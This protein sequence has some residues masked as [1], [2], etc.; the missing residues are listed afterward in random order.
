MRWRLIKHNHGIDIDIDNIPL[1]DEKTFELYQ[2]GET[3]RHFQFE[4]AGMQKYLR[5][6]KPDKFDD[7]I[8]MNALYRP[9]PM[10][11]IPNFI[12]RKHGREEISYDL[13][14]M[15][16]YLK[17]TY[18]ITVYQEQVM[19]LVAK[20][21]GFSKGDADVLRKAMGK[22]QKSVLDKMKSQFI[23]GRHAKGHP[24]DK[25]EKIWTDWEAFAQYAFNKSHSTCYAF[26]AYQT[27]YLKAHYPAEYMAAVL[28]N[29]GNIEKITFFMEE[30]K[31]MG[32]KVLG[33]DIN[34]SRKGFAVNRKARFVLGLAA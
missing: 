12:K 25:L 31:R 5:D 27:A 29:E 34:E 6:L 21:G 24:K 8:A 20:T 9:G 4:S 10:E 3:N 1:D 32:L 28:N 18:G 7:L 22:K 17:D 23:D 13:P 11:Y 19:L 30:C 14:E 15:E 33:P 16:E 2:R 26:V